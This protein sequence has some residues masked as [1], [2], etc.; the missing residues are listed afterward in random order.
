MTPPGSI[1]IPII[2]KIIT[3]VYLYS[4]S[5]KARES[6]PRSNPFTHAIFAIVFSFVCFVV[7]VL[8]ETDQNRG[9]G[10]VSCF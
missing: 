6:S 1:A 2:G 7:V 3:K 10:G 5:W 4:L 8:L 9:T